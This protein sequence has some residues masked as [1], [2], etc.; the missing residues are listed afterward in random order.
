MLCSSIADFHA[1]GDG[2]TKNT[3][4][5]ARAID[6][7]AERGGG[8]RVVVP[9]GTWL[10]GPIHLRS[11]I[12]LH[13]ERG[14]TIFFSKDYADYPLVKTDWEGEEVVRSISP[15][16]GEDLEHVSITGHGVIDGQGEAWRPV[17]KWKM[18]DEQWKK[19][20]GSGGVIEEARQIWWP[21]VGASQG[22]ELVPKLR[23]AHRPVED[24][25]PVREFLRPNMVK[26]T[27]CKHVL[28]D[29]P[30]FQNS[31]AWNVHL[32]LCENVEV[33]NTTILN[34]WWSAN[35]DA[36]DIDACRNVTVRDSHFDCG[37]D[38]ICIKSGKDEAG[39][40]RGRACE[41]VTIEH[42][43]V[44]HGHGGG[45]IGSEMSGGVRN[46]RVSNCIFSGTDIGL[47]FKSTRGRG[48]VV[49]NI[50]IANVSMSNIKHE[51]IS[52]NLFYF[53]KDQRPQPVGEGTPRFRGIHF[54]NITCDGA[55]R[56]IEVRG[57]PEMPIE[58]VSFHNLRMTTTDGVL[59]SDATDITLDD[60]A[61]ETSKCPAMTCHNV[62]GLR[63]VN[64]EF[65]GPVQEVGGHLG[66]L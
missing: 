38:A 19:L 1:V 36:L 11:H 25:L 34:P 13:L 43:T 21:T 47:R 41:N 33:R 45:T 24:Y 50:E 32:L 52:L 59:L 5:F 10:T 61:I 56:A 3:Q 54:R 2:K 58:K 30:T 27:R 16:W 60:V 40:R 15:L 63:T 6:G 46:I 28:I 23:V 49:G 18:T 39:R 22:D 7:L 14:A 35:G 12:D 42:C 48:G 65:T 55:A 66:D 4:A 17:K 44:V 31:A 29:G 53:A 9:A 64:T 26:L 8:G 20:V 57:L 37:D 62:R 51:A